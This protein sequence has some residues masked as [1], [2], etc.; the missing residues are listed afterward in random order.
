MTLLHPIDQRKA[1]RIC[2]G[3]FSL[4][5]FVLT[6]SSLH[7]RR[8][9]ASFASCE[10]CHRSMNQAVVSLEV[11][12]SS[13]EPGETVQVRVHLQAGAS[14]VGGFS[15]TSNGEGT[16]SATGNDVMVDSVF[17]THRT[18]KAASQG[19]V[20][21]DLLWQLP[22]TPG[23]SLLSLA[24][25][26]ADGDNT[27]RGDAI[28]HATAQVIY[29]CEPQTYYRDDDR[30][31][32]G[33]AASG[34]IQDCDVP[35]GYAAVDG[36]CD[37]F[38]SSIYPGAPEL[39]NGRDDDC[40][41]E[42]DEDAQPIPYYPDL[43]G[44]GFGD[45]LATPIESCEP[46][47]GYVDNDDDC[48]DRDPST[49]PEATE[50]CDHVD[51][52]CDGLV[53]EGVREVCGVGLCM[54]EAASCSGGCVPGPALE[55]RCNNVDDDCDGEIDEA[56]ACPQGQRCVEFTCVDADALPPLGVA[57][58]ASP[59]STGQPGVTPPGEPPAPGASSP[60][61]APA[62][63]AP[64]T[65][66]P[67]APNPGA[68]PPAAHEDAPTTAA[69]QPLTPASGASASGSGCHLSGAA[70]TAS[71]TAPWLLLLA[72]SALRRRRGP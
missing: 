37:P 2:C 21:F 67:S 70:T 64:E 12:P 35:P 30:D 50:V 48:D 68:P 5:G 36:D 46:P 57:P 52:D 40:D 19:E 39:C 7:A 20:V 31:G 14:Q 25:V 22:D 9:G 23:A 3:A 26:V 34:T 15:L 6:A 61:P 1:V 66:S 17:A 56:P 8:Q 11:Q 47:A 27:A 41:G 62:G 44:D 58:P 45:P 51:N 18:P 71:T 69:P 63:S 49:H 65:A 72:A 59:V 32:F 16:L 43:D 53:D 13:P 28:G 29:G 42:I 4:L 60:S 38:R 55:E 10:G 24:A 33:D 54:R